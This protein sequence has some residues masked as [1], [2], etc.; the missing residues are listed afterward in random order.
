MVRNTRNVAINKDLHEALKGKAKD[1]GRTISG[2][3]EVL[4]RKV[5]KQEKPK[6]K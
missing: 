5:L 1:E 2:L 4:I 3:V 6:G